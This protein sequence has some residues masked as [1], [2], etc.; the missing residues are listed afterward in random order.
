[1]SGSDDCEEKL[2]KVSIAFEQGLT[3]IHSIR[4]Y[5]R[6]NLTAQRLLEQL[7]YYDFF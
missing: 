7:N 5:L 3:I 1:V 2:S 6:A 4:I